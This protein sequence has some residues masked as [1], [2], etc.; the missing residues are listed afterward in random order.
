MTSPEILRE[1]KK[2]YDNAKAELIVDEGN[3]VGY[4]IINSGTGFRRIPDVKIV[5]N[6][7]G[8]EAYGAKLYPI[9]NVVARKDVILP[10]PVQAI[11]CPSNT[12]LYF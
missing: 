12:N 6:K 8:R 4:D 5:D 11:Y 10:E 9:M 7:C 3:I 2:T 1:D